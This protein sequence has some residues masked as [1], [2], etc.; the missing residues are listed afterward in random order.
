MTL[1]G[2][3]STRRDA[4]PDTREIIRTTYTGTISLLVFC[5]PM[6]FFHHLGATK[7]RPTPSV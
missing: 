3:A 6:R 1:W 5:F 2:A 7:S 4:M